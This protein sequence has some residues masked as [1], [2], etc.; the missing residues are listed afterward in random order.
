MCREREMNKGG[1][2]E[3]RMTEIKGNEEARKGGRKRK[4]MKREKGKRMKRIR[5][6]KEASENGR[7][8]GIYSCLVLRHLLH[9]TQ[10][11]KQ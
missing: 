1:E 11:K 10:T 2:K 3:E 8:R 5:G 7:K 9:Y 6:N 4:V